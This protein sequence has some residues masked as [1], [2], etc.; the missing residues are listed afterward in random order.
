MNLKRD[1]TWVYQH[2]GQEIA[3]EDAPSPGAA[4]MLAWAAGNPDAFYNQVLPK[5]F[6]SRQAIEALERDVDEGT[7]QLEMIAAVRGWKR[8]DIRQ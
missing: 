7:E 3:V 6:P 1:V 2:F 8:E 4:G 5:F